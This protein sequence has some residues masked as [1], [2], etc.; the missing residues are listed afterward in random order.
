MLR[1]AEAGS[2]GFT[3]SG[4]NISAVSTIWMI[5][6]IVPLRNSKARMPL[7][8]RSQIS[9]ALRFA[10]DGHRY[11]STHSGTDTVTRRVATRV[12]ADTTPR[13]TPPCKGNAVVQAIGTHTHTH[14]H[15]HAH[16]HTRTRTHTH[17]HTHTHRH[18][19][20]RTG[21]RVY[22]SRRMRIW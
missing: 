19:H 14:T 2:T 5:V 18:A 4:T 8:L 15:A 20:G 9:A 13:G 22:G 6:S 7:V 12:G 21:V 17:T 11:C 3:A 1:A 16:T 10:G